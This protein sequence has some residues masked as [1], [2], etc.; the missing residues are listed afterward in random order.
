LSTMKTLAL[1][2]LCLA[3]ATASTRALAQS[4]DGYHAIQVFPVAVDTAAFT[5]RFVFRNPDATNAISISVKYLPGTGTSQAAALD[6]PAVAVAANSQAVFTSLRAL[7]PTLAAGSQFGFVY[8]SEANATRKRHYAAYSRVSNAA[9]IGFSVES[10][11]A[12]T[13][14]SADGVVTGARRLAAAGGSPAYQTNCFV[15]KMPTIRPLGN[16]SPDESTVRVS[17]YNAAGVKLGVSTDFVVAAGAITRMLDVF[18]AVGAP[19][20]NHDDARVVFEEIDTAG[21]PGLLNFCT[22]QDNTSFGADFRIAKQEAGYSQYALTYTP[23]AQD[24]HV[25]RDSNANRD[26]FMFGQSQPRDFVVQSGATGSNTHVMYFRHPDYVQCELI[27]PATNVRALAAYGLEMRM[28]DQQGFIVAGGS[29]VV[30]FDSLY[31]GDKASRNSG[32]NTRYTIDVEAS[33]ST[34][35]ARPYR[36]HCVSGSGHTLGDMVRFNEAVDRF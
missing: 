16:P 20:G 26:V 1:A 34:T 30:H 12:H 6:C 33:V 29:D 36:L 19:A 14:T 21:E 9:G 5:Q 15:G 7:C 32:A 22:V 10:F 18:A 25:L 3:A 23:A 17:V 11:P 4:T 8:T 24:E 2:G 13:F 35:T 28:I 31:L 27:D